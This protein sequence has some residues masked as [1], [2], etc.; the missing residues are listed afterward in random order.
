[1]AR[2]IQSRDLSPILAAADVWIT[3]C[4]IADGSIFDGSLWTGPL[5]D[6]VYSAFVEHPDFGEGGFLVKLKGQLNAA[7][8]AAKQLTAEMLWALLLFPSNVKPTTKRQQVVE[9]WKQ[10]GLQL[11]G[12]QPFLGDDVLAGIGSGGPGFNTFRPLELE[13]LVEIVRELKRKTEADRQKLFADYGRFID[14]IEAVAQKGHRQFRHMLR[15]FAFPDRVERM[16]SNND[17]CKI[18]EE[19]KVASR[20]EVATWTD[21]Q[22][23]DALYAL[24]AELQK[25]HPTAVL[26]FYEPPLR[27]RWSREHKIET[28]GGEKTVTIPTKEEEEAT[29]PEAT[30]QAFHS[31]A[32]QSHQVQAKLA[33]IG[34]IMGFRVWLPKGD[35]VRVQELIAKT[36]QSALLEEKLPFN[37]NSAT[38][39]TIEQI[40]VI[41]I[42]KG[43]S[44]NRAFEVEHTTAVYSG[45]LRMADLLALQPNMSIRLSIVAPDERR[46]KVFA[47]MR[48]PVFSR[49]ERVPL[50]ETC[51]FISYESVGAIRD[52]KHLP[53]TNPS[54]LAEYE[55]KTEAE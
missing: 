47:E 23:D 35:R 26:D 44:I 24:R 3:K 8:P 51:T 10:S 11:T 43:G 40:D 1:M 30:P 17:R 21:R 28:I 22:L 25:A 6:E 55:E 45:L 46:E 42:T 7:S 36:L 53:H 54:I 34:A 52:L 27:E 38:I 13:F 49:L 2:L 18:L 29:G 5:V 37:Y 12:E 20:Q 4:L 16:S 32:R 39:A 31:E 9:M 50:S 41:W 33:E 14:W 15:Y 19:F 48:R